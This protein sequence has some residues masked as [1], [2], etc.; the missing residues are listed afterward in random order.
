[1]S[2]CM[3][4][5]LLVGLLGLFSSCAAKKLSP[6]TLALQAKYGELLK[7]KRF[8]LIAV[9]V[10]GDAGKLGL[11]NN[12]LTDYAKLRF[13]NNFSRVS[14]E[15]VSK[16]ELQTLSGDDAKAKKVGVISC[17]VWVV[18]NNYPVA[19]HVRCDEGNYKNLSIWSDEILGYGS[20]PNLP[21]TVKRSISEMMEK[22]AIIY[23][24]VRGEM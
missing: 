3:T 8:G 15:E 6:E 23:F 18:G 17:R 1:M 21:E 2:R 16:E 20:K 24:K 13:K 11:N 10:N 22:L 12:D 5:L 7:I 19:Y 14:Y 4:L 9:N